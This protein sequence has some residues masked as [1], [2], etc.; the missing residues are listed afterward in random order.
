MIQFSKLARIISDLMTLI[1]MYAGNQQKSEVLARFQISAAIRQTPTK[2]ELCASRPADRTTMAS[3]LCAG[4]TRGLTRRNTSWAREEPLE[5]LW[6]V[7]T[8]SKESK[9]LEILTMDC[10]RRTVMMATK[11]WDLFAGKYVMGSTRRKL[12]PCVALLQT[13]VPRR[14]RT[15]LQMFLNL[16]RI[17][18]RQ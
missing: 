8:K 12:E 7:V 18:S 16:L 6:T 5:S 4:G 15:F 11:Q 2:A 9:C 14:L 3:V 13:L 1:R 17:P 10:A